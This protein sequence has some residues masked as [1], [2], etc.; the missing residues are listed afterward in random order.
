MSFFVYS[1]RTVA[2]GALCVLALGGS[3]AG[4]ARI[5]GRVL[6]HDGATLLRADVDV[7]RPV[8]DQVFVTRRAAPDGTFAVDVDLE[9]LV[10]LRLAGVGHEPLELPLLLTPDARVRVAVRLGT[11]LRTDLADVSLLGTSGTHNGYNSRAPAP[12]HRRDD[13]TYFGTFPV[14]HDSCAYQVIGAVVGRSVQGTLADRYRYDGAGDYQ[15]VV[16]TPDSIVRIHFDPTALPGAGEGSPAA[17]DVEGVDEDVVLLADVFR[18]MDRRKR[19]FLYAG[20]TL[21]EAGNAAL[22]ATYVEAW[23]DARAR[24]E[25]EASP[26][27]QRARTL[28]ALQL[29]RLAPGVTDDAFLG[30]ARTLLPP[31]DPLWTLAPELL[32]FLMM[33]GVDESNYA[34]RRQLAWDAFRTHPDPQVRA[35]VALQAMTMTERMERREDTV[36]F[37]ARLSVEYPD[38]P[39]MKRARRHMQQ[40]GEVSFGPVPSFELASLDDPSTTL[41]PAT[42]EGRVLLVDFWATWSELSVAEQPEIHEAYQ[43]YHERGFDVLSVSFDQEPA[44]VE[45]FRTQQWPMPWSHALV[46]DAFQSDIAEAFGVRSLPKP[47]LVDRDGEVVAIGGQLRGER[48]LDVLSRLLSTN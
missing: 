16:A 3:P 40:L 24:A 26:L 28:N 27:L 22:H 11:Y 2:L 25:E 47:V 30:R 42:F 23:P 7:F 4:A 32:S 20:S 17:V 33:N 45:R 6:G 15:S 46:E 41:T 43:T 10:L 39:E 29:L 12:I 14:P 19:N 5:E 44:H 21:D 31:D 48:L 9:G 35:Y 38:T 13:G 36:V 34:S 37:Y 18:Q 8:V 1:L